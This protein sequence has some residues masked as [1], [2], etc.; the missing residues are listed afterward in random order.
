AERL[1]LR[2]NVRTSWVSTRSGLNVLNFLR[3]QFTGGKVA[4][5]GGIAEAAAVLRAS[6]VDV[7]YYWE[8]G[9]DSLNYFLPFYRPTPYQIAGWGWPSTAGHTRVD[10]YYSS[11]WLE[12]ADGDTHYVEK[13]V[14]LPAS[15]TFYHRPPAPPVVSV[16]EKFGLGEGTRVYFCAQNL[17][18]LQPAFDL[19]LTELLR[20][21]L[22]A[23]L[24]LLCDE[25]PTITEQFRARLTA[26]APEVAS[27]WRCVPRMP[28]P[29]YL[30]LTAGCD[31]LLDTPGYGGGANTA[32]DAAAVGAPVVTWTGKYHRGRWQSAVNSRLGVEELNVASAEAYL[33]TCDA[34]ARDAARRRSLSERILSR[35]DA[36]FS[37]E[38]AVAAFEAAVIAAASGRG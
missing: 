25:Q 21:D 22:D 7:L 38:Q 3:P 17:R 26:A 19:V 6:D 8:V 23:R 36:L 28:R 34:V 14:R 5:P 11:E 35:A 31:V 2:G 20:R 24:L 33:E 27:R 18:K 4:I 37:D 15:P 10:A 1:A 29:E 13:L 32:L 16:R 12:P 9:T 30:S